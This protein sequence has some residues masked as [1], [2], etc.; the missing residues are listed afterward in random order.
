MV[1]PTRAVGRRIAYAV[2]RACKCA[3]CG[4]TNLGRHAARHVHGTHCQQARLGRIPCKWCAALCF[5][6]CFC[7]KRASGGRLAYCCL[8]QGLT[9]AATKQSFIAGSL[10]CRTHRHRSVRETNASDPSLPHN[11]RWYS[12]ACTGCLLN[13]C[14]AEVGFSSL[15]SLLTLHNPK[16]PHLPIV[17]K[18]RRSSLTSASLSVLRLYRVAVRH[19]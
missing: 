14:L 17:S 18:H 4:A 1:D 10:I 12:A 15:L 5:C 6:F 13:F 3:D 2:P 19:R 9:L 8:F 16:M 11:S 7:N